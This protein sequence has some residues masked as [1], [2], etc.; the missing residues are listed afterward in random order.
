[1]YKGLAVQVLADS[2]GQAKISLLETQGAGKF[3]MLTA[4]GLQKAVEAQ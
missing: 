4:R 1:M 2:L 3:A